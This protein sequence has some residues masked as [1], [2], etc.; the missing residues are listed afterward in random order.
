MAASCFSLMARLHITARCTMAIVESNYKYAVIKPLYIKYVTRETLWYYCTQKTKNNKNKLFL[1]DVY[2]CAD[3]VHYFASGSSNIFW[4]A[5]S[6]F[7]LWSVECCHPSASVPW[8]VLSLMTKKAG[9]CDGARVPCNEVR[10]P[11][12]PAPVRPRSRQP[13]HPHHANH[14]PLDI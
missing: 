12:G 13:Q 14:S 1:D 10:H 11:L 5:P 7:V 3:I 4:E 8:S 9:P 2:W 6:I